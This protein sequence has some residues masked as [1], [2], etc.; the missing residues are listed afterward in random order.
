M[1]K[2]EVS[3]LE[4]AKRRSGYALET[5]IETWSISARR[6]FPL[7]GAWLVSLALPVVVL[8]VTVFG[9]LAIDFTVL[10]ADHASWGTLLGLL[11]PGL[12]IGWLWGG[13]NYITLKVVRGLPVKPVDMFRPFRQMAGAVVALSIT[14]VLIALTS[15]LVIVGPLLFLKWQLAAFYIVDRGYG[16]IQA[17]KKSW[18]DT[19]MV[20][21]PLL[22]LDLSLFGVGCAFS[23]ITAITVVGPLLMHIAFTVASAIVYAKW[24]TDENNPDLPKQ[25]ADL[26]D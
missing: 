19:D 22:I 26:D 5:F 16:P 25:I 21:V 24:L 20:F 14:S 12:V 13:W 23:A 10:R 6:F 15:P 8:I 18:H 3:K 11:I 2:L 17:L 7:F 1:D 4:L 9:G